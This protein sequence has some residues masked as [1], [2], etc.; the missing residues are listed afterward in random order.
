MQTITW[1]SDLQASVRKTKNRSSLVTHGPLTSLEQKT[2]KN[3]LNKTHSRRPEN[4]PRY[5]W[6]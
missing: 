1:S 5:L 2:L 4:E 3:V 6:I